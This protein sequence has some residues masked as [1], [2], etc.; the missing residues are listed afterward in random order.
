MPKRA[1][2]SHAYAC[3]IWVAPKLVLALCTIACSSILLFVAY[4]SHI[5]L[6]P[7][8][9]KMTNWLVLIYLLVFLPFD[10]HLVST[11]SLSFFII[12]VN[13]IHLIRYK[14][15]SKWGD[16]INPPQSLHFEVISV[17]TWFSTFWL[18]W[19]STGSSVVKYLTSQYLK[20]VIGWVTVSGSALSIGLDS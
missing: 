19:P 15:T 13:K 4:S 17:L 5:L 3:K 18:W 11:L 9:I 20:L 16:F 10:I 1:C 8:S 12:V 6:F 7:E 14:T 2:T